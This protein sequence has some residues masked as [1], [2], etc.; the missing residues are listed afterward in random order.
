MSVETIQFALREMFA[1]PYRS[2]TAA[3]SSFGRTPPGSLKT[4]WR[5]SASPASSA[6]GSPKTAASPPRCSWPTPS[7][8]WRNQLVIS[9]GLE[10]SRQAVEAQQII[11]DKINKL[12]LKNAEALRMSAVETAREVERPI[13]DME[14]LRKCN[15]ELITSI[16]E[17]VKIHEE[18]VKIETELK[19]A[20]L[21]AGSR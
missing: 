10:H 17:V 8:L 12:L 7:P 13:V 19:Q 14:P 20:L 3:A 11:S 4:C 1:A 18:L 9:L 21:E 15:R 16:N 2:S 5:R 6:C